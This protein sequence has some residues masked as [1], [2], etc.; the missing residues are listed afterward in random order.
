LRLA[1]REDGVWH[2]YEV[3]DVKGAHGG[4]DLLDISGD[5][6]SIELRDGD[7]GSHVLTTLSDRSKVSRIVAGVL[8]ARTTPVDFEAL[9]ESPLFVRFV[10][11]DGTYVERPWH[12]KA[13]LLA[14]QLAAPQELALLLRAD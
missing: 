10:L 14:T 2:V 4:A 11:G 9:D 7:T 6:R 12:V 8:S 5:V 13:G 1:V 3:S